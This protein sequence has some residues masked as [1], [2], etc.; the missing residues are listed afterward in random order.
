MLFRSTQ[1]LSTTALALTLIVFAQAGAGGGR[2]PAPQS[3]TTPA[4]Q[5]SGSFDGTILFGAPLA[6]TGSLSNEGNLSHEGYELWKEVYN[7][8][9]GIVVGGKRFKIDTKYYDDESNAQKSATLAQKLIKEDKVNFLLGPYGTSANLQVS[10]IAEKNQI[11]MVEGNGV[12]ESIFGQGYQYTFL[13][14]S[15][16]PVY[17][18]GIIDMALAQD[19]KPSTVAILSADDPFSMEVANAANKYALQKGLT[20]VY[21]QKYPNS[22]TDLRA[23][24]TETKSKNPDLF[25]NSGHFA[26]SVAIAQQAKELNFV[27]KGYGFSVGPSLPNFQTTLKND[28]NYITNGTQWTADLK[29]VGVDL[30]KTS[31]VYNQMFKDRWGH[32][33]PYQSANSTVSGIAFGKALE[34]AGT[35][36]PRAVRDQLAKLDVMTFYG[37]IKFD[38]RGVN[39]YKPMVVEQWQKGKKATIWPTAEA[40][41]KPLWPAPAWDQR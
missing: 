20:V 40:S 26:E 12:A 28:A 9:G 10:T 30:F 19:P 18:S 25:L 5:F 38:E 11:P 22:S 4:T 17:L 34:A 33:P 29:Y 2:G 8:L 3:P 6:L 41:A 24:L 7:R 14:A 39:I 16:A 36:D 13:V 1:K 23:P 15:P 31:Q 35:L 32:E 21:A 27:A 37:Q